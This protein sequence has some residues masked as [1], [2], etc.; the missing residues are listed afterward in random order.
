MLVR[1]VHVPVRNI[2]KKKQKNNCGTKA[3]RPLT[4]YIFYSSYLQSL[5][6]VHA[7][8]GVCVCVLGWMCS[9]IFPNTLS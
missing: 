3:P 7:T 5:I 1:A 8:S 4:L 9:D 6:A 2:L